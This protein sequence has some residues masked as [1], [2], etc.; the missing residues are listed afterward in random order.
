MGGVAGVV[1]VGG[2]G[3]WGDRERFGNGAI[4]EYFFI[5][6]LSVS[7]QELVIL[8]SDVA[9]ALAPPTPIMITK[10]WVTNL[11][12]LVLLNFWQ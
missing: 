5:E 1:G 10:S 11:L 9:A 6:P 3:R 7:F 12:L 8:S 2:V 4:I